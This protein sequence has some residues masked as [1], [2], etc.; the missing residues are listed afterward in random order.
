MVENPRSSNT[1]SK[2]KFVLHLIDFNCDSTW[3]FC[4]L[5]QAFYVIPT[6]SVTLMSFA[7]FCILFQDCLLCMGCWKSDVCFSMCIA[8]EWIAG[9]LS[10]TEYDLASWP[11]WLLNM[12]HLSTKTR[13]SHFQLLSYVGCVGYVVRS[14]WLVAMV[15]DESSNKLEP[16]DPWVCIDIIA[17]ETLCRGPPVTDLCAHLVGR[18]QASG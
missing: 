6:N 3:A 5:V 15:S 11:S 16:L 7:F 8:A 13:H 4:M 14:L 9:I 1:I 2:F 18:N 17:F 10:H 12:S